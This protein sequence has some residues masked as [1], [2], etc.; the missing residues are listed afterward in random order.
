MMSARGV[1]KLAFALARRPIETAQAMSPRNR[2]DRAGPPDEALRLGADWLLRAQAQSPDGDGYSRRFSL[3]RGWDR[4]YVETTGY[5]I[6]TLLD[7]APILGDLYRESALRAARWLLT[8]QDSSGAFHDL[9]SDRPQVFDTGQVTLGLSRALRETGDERFRDAL[10]R[11]ATWLIAEQEQDG[12]W[13]RNAYLGRPHAYYSRVGAALI[14]AGQVLER[15]EC[16][17]AGK[18]SL[19]WVLEQRN[20]NGYFRFSEF[21]PDEDAL[22][23][24][25]VYVLEGFVLAADLTGESRWVDVAVDG[26]ATLR[27][28]ANEHGLLH[29]QYAPTWDV[30]NSEYCVTGLAQYAGLCSDIA[31]LTGDIS[32]RRAGDRVLAELG[33]WQQVRGTN[34]KGGLQSSIPIWGYYGGMEFFNWNVKFFLDALLKRR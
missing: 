15:D 23:H 21:R 27:E 24:T 13:V 32:F 17:A 1:T 34:I 28:R 31:R 9:D 20:A 26:A 12:S 2:R 3:L 18:R 22:L 11:A 10:D 8:A 30:T 6:P 5:I 7:A 33:P 4:G 19:E 29:S 25:L 14:E 16:L